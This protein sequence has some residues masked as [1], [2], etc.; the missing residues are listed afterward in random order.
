MFYDEFPVVLIFPWFLL[1]FICTEIESI[2]C[3]SS[4]FETIHIFIFSGH[5]GFSDFSE[6]KNIHLNLDRRIGFLKGYAL[7]EYE[8]MRKKTTD[9][10]DTKGNDFEDYNLKPKMVRGPNKHLKRLVAAKYKSVLVKNYS[11]RVS[12]LFGTPS[13][14][15]T[16]KDPQ[17][18]GYPIKLLVEKERNKEVLMTKLK[19]R[20]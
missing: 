8:T 20:N 12:K 4:N 17:F 13:L 15:N 14:A 7:V 2:L 16:V 1:S 10:T 5:D 11:S 6:I 3:S 18:I 19:R 9:F